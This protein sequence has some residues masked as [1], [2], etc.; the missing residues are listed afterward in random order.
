MTV[1]KKK[2]EVW[3][4]NTKYDSIPKTLAAM[5]H[6]P[7]ADELDRMVSPIAVEVQHR[8]LVEVAIRFKIPDKSSL[9]AMST[10]PGMIAFG[11]IAIESSRK[12]RLAAVSAGLVPL[13]SRGRQVTPTTRVLAETATRNEARVADWEIVTKAMLPPGKGLRA[14]CLG[15]LKAEMGVE[16]DRMAGLWLADKVCTFLF[17]NNTKIVILM[18]MCMY[19]YMYVYVNVPATH[20]HAYTNKKILIL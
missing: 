10:D 19:A 7:V 14:L 6:S 5:P 11:F 4:P 16:V 12:A 9:L 18:C 8:A 17:T 1:T 13:S 2:S 3:S 20:T 15:E